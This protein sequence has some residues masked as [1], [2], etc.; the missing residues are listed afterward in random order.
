MRKGA[1][2]EKCQGIPVDG[3]PH[4]TPGIRGTSMSMESFYKVR[5]QAPEKQPGEWDRV[6]LTLDHEGEPSGECG[7]EDHSVQVASVIG[8][9][10][11]LPFGQTLQSAHRQSHPRQRE[12]RA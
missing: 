3:V 5:A 11:A 12:K 4:D 9:D 6:H 8:N 1:F 10:H 2:R 7:R